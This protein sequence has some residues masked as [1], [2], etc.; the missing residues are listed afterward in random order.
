MI[1]RIKTVYFSCISGKTDENY[2]EV[3][4]KLQTIDERTIP[5]NIKG[6]LKHTL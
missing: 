2:E 6:K 1:Y 5:L 3:K 4:L